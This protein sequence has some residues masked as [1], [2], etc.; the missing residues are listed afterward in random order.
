MTKF[1]EID[2]EIAKHYEQSLLNRSQPLLMD[3]FSYKNTYCH[4]YTLDSRIIVRWWYK[5][6]RLITRQPQYKLLHIAIPEPE[7]NTI[8]FRRY[9]NFKAKEV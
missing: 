4:V 7:N 3:W 9:H 1:G 8:R 6:K 2:Q 5:L